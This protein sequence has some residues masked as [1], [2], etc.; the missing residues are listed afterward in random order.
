[1]SRSETV[2]LG[3]DVIAAKHLVRLQSAMGFGESGRHFDARQSDGV[4]VG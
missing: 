2:R 3:G 4:G 1:V